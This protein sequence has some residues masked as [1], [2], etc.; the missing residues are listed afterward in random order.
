MVQNTPKKPRGRPPA[1][2]R[3][4][5]LQ[6][7]GDAFWD[8]GY[9]ATTLDDLSGAT[10]MNRPSLYGAFGDKHALY[11]ETLAIYSRASHD[12]LDAYLA[13]D[14]VLADQ[15][16]AVYD[17]ALGIYLSG[18]RSPRGCFLIGTA[19]SEAVEDPVVRERLLQSLLQ[20]DD[21]FEARFL[22]AQ[23]MGEL[24]RDVDARALGQVA[25]AT[26]NALAVRA[27]AGEKLASLRTTAAMTV[28]L[29]CGKDAAGKVRKAK[30]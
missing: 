13:Q 15:L 21:A 30:P 4:Q 27:R 25:A 24:A 1:Y 2:D 12:R 5:A 7:A 17:G 26:L 6:Q 19:L 11:L 8:A 28:R 16:M 14:G 29:I 23:A 10:G 18:E 20:F 22:R 9:S 3:G